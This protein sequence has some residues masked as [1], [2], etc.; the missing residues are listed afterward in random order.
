MAGKRCD[1]TSVRSASPP[2]PPARLPQGDAS[3][4]LARA[5]QLG[6]PGHLA[7]IQEV[8]E[9]A[10]NVGGFAG[11]GL[12]GIMALRVLDSAPATHGSTRLNAPLQDHDPPPAPPH[13]SRARGSHA[14][15]RDGAQARRSSAGP[16]PGARP[17]PTLTPR[18]PPHTNIPHA[19]EYTLERSLDAMQAA[20]A[21]VKLGAAAWRATGTSTLRGTDEVQQLLDDQVGGVKVGRG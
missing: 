6:V 20:W 15:A 5:L 19:Q 11:V 12:L 9:A 18:N 4:S 3:F 13:P 2:T 16:G 10:N 8:A 17:Q 21:G 1:P 7:A 14:G